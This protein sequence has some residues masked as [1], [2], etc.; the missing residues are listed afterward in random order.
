MSSFHVFLMTRLDC[1]Y[2][3]LQREMSTGKQA[4]YP[5]HSRLLGID[6]ATNAYTVCRTDQT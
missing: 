3:F 2:H 5:F 6:Q 1:I 4:R